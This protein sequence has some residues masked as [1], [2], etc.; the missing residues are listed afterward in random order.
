MG[1]DLDLRGVPAAD[2]SL[3]Y[4]AVTVAGQGK[5]ELPGQRLWSV[6]VQETS[7]LMALRYVSIV[8]ESPNGRGRT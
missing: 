1:D 4:K 5:V 6:S 8:L 3:V 7:P 2:H